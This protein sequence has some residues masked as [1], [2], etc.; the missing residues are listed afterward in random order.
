MKDPLKAPELYNNRELS[1]LEFNRRV[2]SL[3]TRPD[4]PVL[5]RLKFIAIT[6]SN[7]DEFYMVRVGGLE[8]HRRRGEARFEPG[9]DG[10]GLRELLT[11][12]SDHA[13]ELYEATGRAL[14]DSVLPELAKN[15]IRFLGRDEVDPAVQ[16]E[17]QEFYRREVHPCLTPIAIDPAHPFPMLKNGTLNLALRVQHHPGSARDD[18]LEQP[19]GELLA[20]V[21]VP[22]MLPRFLPLPTEDGSHLFATLEDVIARFAHNLFPGYDIAEAATFRITR[23]SDL[24][25]DEEDAEDLLTTIQDELRRRD[26]GEPVRLEVSQD[27]SPELTEKLRTL[28][29]VQQRQVLRAPSFVAV[30]ALMKVY[31]S[32]SMPEL[33]DDPFTPAPVE[34]LRYTPM[35]FRAIRERDILMHHPYESFRHVVDFIDLAAKDPDV[36]AIKQTLYR[37][38]GDS[39][40][41]RSLARAAEA[42]KQVTALV[43]LKAR[44][45]EANNIQWA[46]ALEESGVHVVYGLIGLKTHCK[47]LLVTR[48]E[49]G[50]LTRYLHLATGN[51]HPSTARLYTDMGLFTAREDMTHDAMLLFNVLTGYAE[52]PKMQRLIVSPFTLRQHV[53]RSIEREIEHAQAGRPAGIKAKMNSLVDGEVIRALYRASQAGVQIDLMVRGICCLRPQVPGVSENIRVQSILDRF[54]EHTR[55]FWWRN[56]G[57]DEVYLSSAD[58][59]PRNLNR[60]IEVAFPV[61]DPAIQKR[62]VEDIIPVEMADNTFAWDQGPDGQYSLRS[63]GE[64]AAVRAQ[65]TFVRLTRKRAHSVRKAVRPELSGKLERLSPALRAAAAQQRRQRQEG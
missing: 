42:G 58:W 13:R 20:V 1:W 59:M 3:A 7:L 2:L 29:H 21:Q 32:L 65:A 30:S 49:G 56:G 10:L 5:E 31:G 36:V 46:M 60:R 26:R 48:R 53:L 38:S 25:I 50:K 47:M 4:V 16:D 62:I 61:L 55:V 9:P 54:L 45:D 63:P 27:T 57:E 18:R 43:E 39:P 51:Y 15:G 28:A 52:L 40:I 33:K 6:G 17:L 11:Q 19:E 24:D 12:V 44:F 23:S 35:M 34:R 41:V 64:A 14:L 22:S 37:T 8:R